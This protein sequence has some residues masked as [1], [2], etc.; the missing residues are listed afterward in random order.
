MDG[1]LDFPVT[2]PPAPGEAVAIAPGILWLRMKLP[3]ALNHINL[4]LVED[5]PCG[6]PVDTGFSLPETQE[7]WEHIF[8]AQLGG[9]RIRRGSS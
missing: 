5:G 2:T 8:A 3:F 9:R 1:L 4:W 7:A 6:P